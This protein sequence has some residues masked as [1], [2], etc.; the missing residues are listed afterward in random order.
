MGKKKRALEGAV[1]QTTDEGKLAIIDMIGKQFYMQRFPEIKGW[2]I[3][4]EF[5]ETACERATL[6]FIDKGGLSLLHLDVTQLVSLE[7]GESPEADK[8]GAGPAVERA[9][10]PA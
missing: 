8:P 7:T 6:E 1:R 3:G 5:H 4:V 2:V 10:S 9:A